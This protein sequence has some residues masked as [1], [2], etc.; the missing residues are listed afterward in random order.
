[1][2]CSQQIANRIPLPIPTHTQFPLFYTK[3]KDT[4]QIDNYAT[5]LAEILNSAIQTVGRP[6]RG[7]GGKAPWWSAECEDAYRDHLIARQNNLDN[8]TPLETRE[9]LSIVRKAK[10]EYWRHVINRA[11]DD[12]SLY[13]VIGWHKLSSTLKAPPLEV[14][15][16]VVE[17]T[18]EK[19]EALQTEI[20]ERFSA[21]DNLDLDLLANWDGT[22][23]L[24]WEQTVSLE[25]VE[26]NT[27]SVS[28]TSPGTD[29]V[30]VRLLKAGLEYIKHVVHGLYSRCLALNYFLQSWKLAEVVMLPKIGKKDKT[31]VRSWRPVAL[32]SCISKGLE[33]IIAQ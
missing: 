2:I 16:T 30:T 25:E 3:I 15:G 20:L 28:S 26:Q 9:F 12:K 18:I 1:L 22:G 23:Y 17:D 10:R 19:A 31:S 24:V 7:G 5:T 13:K 33:C 11:S 14:N 6:D 32:L 4:T 21:A 27:I 8:S 29:R